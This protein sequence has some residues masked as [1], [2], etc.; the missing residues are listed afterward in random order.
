MKTK[1]LITLVFCLS[2]IAC[3]AINVE[4]NQ[5]KA[6]D[7]EVWDTGP[8]WQIWGDSNALYAEIMV[9]YDGG[10][11]SASHYMGG[12]STIWVK[13]MSE[14]TTINE[15]SMARTSEGYFYQSTMYDSHIESDYS[16]D[17]SDSRSIYLA[18]KVIA[19]DDQSN[20]FPV[21]GW[22]EVSAP[23][24]GSEPKILPSAWDTD[25]GAMIVG[26]GAVPEPT[27]GLLLLLGVAGLALRRKST[28]ASRVRASGFEGQQQ[29]FHLLR[30]SSR[31]FFG[32][33]SNW[34]VSI[35]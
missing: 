29:P 32:A 17:I 34:S 10:I 18:F 21:Y 35:E 12:G 1:T 4:W 8:L 28:G 33:S 27:S 24:P 15:E 16:I 20:P 25:G 14:G 2:C 23:M 6:V 26:A 31:T 5:M 11:L 3:H 22:V 30:I 19:Y 7:A 9:T 13:Q